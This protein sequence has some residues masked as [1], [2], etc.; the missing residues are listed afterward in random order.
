MPDLFVGEDATA[1]RHHEV[2]GTVLKHG[3]MEGLNGGLDVVGDSTHTSD[4]V[5]LTDHQRLVTE[6]GVQGTQNL[7]IA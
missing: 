5:V 3:A 2:K 1:I 6:L 4:V 7:A